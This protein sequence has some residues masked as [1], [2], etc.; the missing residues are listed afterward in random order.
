MRTVQW[1][2]VVAAAC[3]GMSA[4]IEATVQQPQPRGIQL[5]AA[6]LADFDKRVN[7]YMALH[8]KAES[9]QPKLS[10]KATPE[11]ITKSKDAL[12]LAIRAARPNAAAGGLLTPAVQAHIRRVFTAVFAGTEG[13]NLKG[14]IMDENP[15]G[16]AIKVNDRYPTTVPL[17][18]M[19]PSVLSALPKLPEELEY[20]FVGDALVIMDGHADLI[21]D[22]M[23]KSLPR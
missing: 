23:P 9:E 17:S 7:E 22:L 10:D 16:L 2:A 1:A 4:T 11:E 21:V 19:P 18:T 5:D 14:S 3:L 20:R 12:S 6:T 8:K 15:V 13:A